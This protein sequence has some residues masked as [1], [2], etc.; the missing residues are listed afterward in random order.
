M[1]HVNLIKPY[2]PR[3][4]EVSLVA[5][6]IS[7]SQDSVTATPNESSLLDFTIDTGEI[8]LKNSDVL[9]NLSNKL[10]HLSQKQQADLIDLL[11]EF[12]D[13]FGDVPSQCS[14]MVHEVTLKEGSTPIRQAPYRLPPEKKE[15][16]FMLENH[17]AV[18]SKSEW[19]SPCLLTPKADG[20]VRMCTDYRKVNEITCGDSY[21]LPRIDDI[22][23]SIGQA[24][25]VTKLDMLKGYYQIKLSEKA[26]KIS[27]FVTPDGLFEYV[28]MP[29]GMKCAPATFQRLINSIISGMDGVQAYL[30]DSVIYSASWEKHL[31]KL[32][33]LLERL[34]SAQLTVNLVKSDFAKAQL[35]YLG[36]TVGGGMLTPID[37]KVEA[38]LNYPAPTTRREVQRYLGMIGYYRRFIKDFSQLA[39]PLTDLTSSKKTFHWTEDCQEAFETLKRFLIKDPILRTPDF[40]K[41]FELQVDASNDGIGAVLLQDFEGQKH[42]ICYHSAKLKAHQRSY[43]TPEKEALALISALEKFYVYLGSSGQKIMVYSDHNP[44]KFVHQFKLKNQRLTRWALALQPYD[45]EIQHIKGCNNVFADALSRAVK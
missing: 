34:R 7:S 35:D 1:V 23:D 29:F 39:A 31:A 43:S 20:S 33:K 13:L 10:S 17:L 19:A 12:K 11:E 21:P 6:N 15:L 32:R 44:L 18:P 24:T 8:K 2:H 37:S 16:K 5:S 42:P 27:A 4:K 28:V 38:I 36:Y 25:Y 41:P 30:D 40:N 45:L 14:L 3:D 26:R 9:N 22:I